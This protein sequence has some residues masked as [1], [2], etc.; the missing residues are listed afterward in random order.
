[1]LIPF[2]KIVVVGTALILIFCI[3]G[4]IKNIIYHQKEKVEIKSFL[5]Q[6][7]LRKSKYIDKSLAIAVSDAVRQRFSTD[8]SKWTFINRKQEPFLKYSALQ[9]LRHKEGKCGKA[10]RV[11]IKILQYLGYDAA[12]IS[13]LERDL[14]TRT[15]HTLIS[16]VIEG[17]EYFIDS[18]NSPEKFNHFIK[19]N[20]PNTDCFINK[21]AKKKLNKVKGV[22]AKNCRYINDRFVTYNYGIPFSQILSDLEIDIDVFIYKRPHKI[23][24]YLIE[25]VYL[26]RAILFM[27]VS[28]ISMFIILIFSKNKSKSYD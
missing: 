7:K 6:N 5:V 12:R 10:A 22:D 14:N 27:L 23:S 13:L 4:T 19:T 1:M 28:V 24:S 16:I 8:Q 11:I 20:H 2:K 9:L 18:V 26:L 3:L 17:K 25:S 21:R 15:G